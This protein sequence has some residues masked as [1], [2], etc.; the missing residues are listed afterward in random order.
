LPCCYRSS[1]LTQRLHL[2]E[3]DVAPQDIRAPHAISFQSEFLTQAAR[4]KAAAETEPVYSMTDTSIARRQ[5]ERLRVILA[6]ISNV[7]SDTYAET[8]QKLADLAAMEDIQLTQDTA[9]RIIDLSNS[10]WETVQREAILVLER[11]MQNTIREDRLEDTRRSVP[12]SISLALPEDQAHIVAELVTAFVVPNSIYNQDLTEAARQEAIQSVA[13]LARSFAAGETIVQRGSVITASDIEAL[14]EFGLLQTQYRWQDMFSIATLV[15]LSTSFL[16][17]YFGRKDPANNHL[18]KVTVITLLFLTFLISTRLITPGHTVI[19]YLFPLAA[20]GLIVAALFGP[21]PAL[22]SMIPLSILATYGLPYSL[23]LAIYYAFNGFVGILILGKARRIISFFWTSF[24]MAVAGIA[25]V[26]IYRLP[27]PT[28]DWTG[29]VTLIGAAIVNGAAA[30][31]LALL[32]QFFLAQVL[33]MTTAL[34]LL[35]L[36]RP[37]HPLLQLLLRNAPGTYQH[38]LQVANLAEQAA[39]VIQADALLTRVGAL[40]HDIGKAADAVFFIENQV[41]GNA[42]PHDTMDPSTSASI[43]IRH[44]PK[45]IELARKYRLPNRIQDFIREHHGATITRYQ[46]SKALEA[47]GGN[48]ET[49][50]IDEFT[51]PGPRPQSRETAL[52]MLADGCEARVRAERPKDETEL[53]ALIK[54]VVDTAV[55]Y[56]NLNDTDLTLQDLD[57]IVDSFS[58]TLRGIY[59]P[60]IQYPNTERTKPIQREEERKPELPALSAENQVASN[61]DLDSQAG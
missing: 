29:L 5:L 36:S 26:I 4:Q 18:R 47:A 56:G 1:P 27:E 28:T 59:H 32:M 11:V 19:P 48:N 35:E 40:Y 38:S 39:E 10:R 50:D 17:I 16:F 58:A 49:I 6:Y 25:I 7:R 30:S 22:I 44:I 31:G 46:Y 51:Y 45:G 43:I 3:G 20:Y 52:L 8:D 13:P 34:Q 14:S 12:A 15:L 55:A 2:K 21:E 57:K 53:R 41:P 23:Q 60:R 33:G 54:N 24:G 42:N 61:P 9:L 37:D